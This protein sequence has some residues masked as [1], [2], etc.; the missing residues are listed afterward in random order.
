M[1]L[2]HILL[3]S[4]CWQFVKDSCIC[5]HEGYWS[6]VVLCIV[7]SRLVFVSGQ[8]ML[9]NMSLELLPSPF[10]F[11]ETVV[12]KCCEFFKYLVEF[13]SGSNG[14]WRFLFWE[15]LIMISI[16]LIVMGYLNHLF[17]MGRV[18]VVCAFSGCGHLVYTVRFLCVEL[19][20]SPR[21]SDTLVFSF[22]FSFVSLTRTCPFYDLFR[23]PAL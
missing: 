8:S 1:L 16:S 18:V 10:Y 7:L 20:S 9:L 22:C 23:E 11:L 17:H 19:H 3:T 13:C 12:S 21:P 6:V 14:A 2:F 15:F 5:I 4:M